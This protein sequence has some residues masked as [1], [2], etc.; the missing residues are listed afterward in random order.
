[1]RS[2]APLSG[3]RILRCP[4][5]RC[6]LHTWLGS[7][8]AVAVAWAGGYSSDSTPSLGLPHATGAALKTLNK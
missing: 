6:R 7:Q 4:E 5:L 8:V 3:L 2:L 1:M